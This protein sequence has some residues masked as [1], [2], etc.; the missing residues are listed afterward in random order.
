MLELLFLLLPIAAAYGWVMG[1]RSVKKQQE[2]KSHQFS[3][4]YM[5]GVNLLL[6]NQQNKAVDLFLDILQK[7]ENEAGIEGA[8]PF[9]AQLTLGN[10]FRSRGEVDKAI[11]IHKNLLQSEHYSDEQKIL[12]RKQ[13]AKDFMA[14]GF[15]D[16][17][18]HL[19]TLLVDEPDF[20]QDAL[21]QLAFIYQKTKE[22]DKAINVAEK[23][24]RI[25]PESNN[26]ALAHYYCERSEQLTALSDPSDDRKKLVSQAKILLGKALN[27][28]PSCIRASLLLA[29]MALVQL[30]EQA[31]IDY[32][33]NVLK[34]NPAFIGEIIAPLAYIYQN[35]GD[36]ESFE[37]F[38][39]KAQQALVNTKVDLALLDLTEQQLGTEAAKMKVQHQ[40]TVNPAPRL[41][42]RFVQ[43][44]IEQTKT[45][46]E[47]ANLELIQGMV[48]RYL[49]KEFEYRCTN[50][51]FQTHKLLWNCPSCQKW[52][53]IQPLN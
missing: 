32:L 1:Y 12:T 17:A 39:I 24:Q 53:T 46:T 21:Q 4:D 37:L 2:N 14:I 49:S 50:C 8:S 42:L 51:G 48:E 18:E 6:A 25:A 19:Y 41:F 36:M 11:R 13:L 15:Y 7:Q 31:A 47:K 29:E 28:S 43:Y 52:E 30:N 9:E 44:Q 45:N 3:R 26:V 40:L 38:L 34:Q 27:V 20:A 33:Q 23:Y 35:R 10:L 22:W 16:R 5:A